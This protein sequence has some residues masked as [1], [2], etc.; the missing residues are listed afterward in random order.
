MLDEG[1]VAFKLKASRQLPGAPGRRGQGR[2]GGDA[3]PT[4]PQLLLKTAAGSKARAARGAGAGA[5]GRVRGRGRGRGRGKGGAEAGLGI[6]AG[7][8]GIGW[9]PL[10]RPSPRA[11]WWQE[12]GA[13]H[14][15]EEGG[16]A[17]QPT[18]ERSRAQAQ[19]RP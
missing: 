2:R 1:R 9:H 19:P 4:P 12:S 18:K 7:A 3:G 5:G 16:G 17:L 15:I 13:G 10:R 14:P 11:R 8:G 6:G